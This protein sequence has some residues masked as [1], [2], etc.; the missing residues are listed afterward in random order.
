MLIDLGKSNGSQCGGV[1]RRDFLK[2]GALT[3]GGLTLSNLLRQ[4]AVGAESG[5]K[6]AKGKDLS[7]ILIWHPG[8]PSHLDMWDLKPNAPSD[9]RG[10][11]N[12]IKTNLD[13]YQCSELM[14]NVAKICDKLAIVRSVTHS[15]SHHGSAQHTLLTGYKASFETALQEMPSMGSIISKEMGPREP[16]FPAYVAVPGA[17]PSQGA[18]YLGIAHNPFEVD[19]DPNSADFK[20]RNLASTGGIS[21]ERLQNR[22]ERLKRFDTMRRESDF[23]GSIKGMDDFSRMAFD[24]VTSPKAQEAF[25]LNKEDPKIRDRYGRNSSGQSALLGRRLVEAG[26]RFVTMSMGYWDTH[27]D[28]FN[29]HKNKLVPPFDQAFAA[30]VQDLHDRGRLDKTLILVWGEFGRTP[31]INK[32]AGRDHHPKVFTAV[33]AGGGL[34]RGL[35]LGESDAHGEFPKERPVSP[36]DVLATVYN[37]LGVDRETT[38]VN[39]AGRPVGI[40]GH[41]TP[42][43]EIIN[44]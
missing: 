21:L 13:G 11:F 22:Q 29:S 28:N 19:S 30:L 2:A 27:G 8:G 41:G 3:F 1:V 16:G 36:Q 9:L 18:A 6:S 32:E 44:T 40:L 12:P 14:P 26:V 31:R 24:L 20:V 37:Q 7:V 17:S 5:V 10:I 43:P 15:D 25:D 4:Q 38:Y 35:V 39:E 23:T 42:I 33:M 34:K